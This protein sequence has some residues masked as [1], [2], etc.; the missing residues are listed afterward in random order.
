M[1]PADAGPG[2][3]FPRAAS[4]VDADLRP[5]GLTG[6][7]ERA[8]RTL[9]EQVATG[10]LRLEPTPEPDAVV[11]Q[12]LALPGIGRWTAAYVAMRALREPDAFPVADLGLCR[13]L[14]MGAAELSRVAES[15]RP[16]RAYAAMLLW[17]GGP[18][19]DGRATDPA[20]EYAASRG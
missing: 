7:R 18:A 12:L 5:I 17:Q 1:A 10:R 13:A 14:D 19:S 11:E 9:A 6:A 8:I 16:W 3:L 20:S 2:Q 4:L 15:W